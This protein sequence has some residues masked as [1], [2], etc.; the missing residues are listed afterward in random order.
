MSAEADSA[1]I[2]YNRQFC[3]SKIDQ[4]CHAC[5][6]VSVL[7]TNGKRSATIRVSRRLSR[8]QH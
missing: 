5:Q 2:G 6:V 7:I 4:H 3:G 8:H 1:S